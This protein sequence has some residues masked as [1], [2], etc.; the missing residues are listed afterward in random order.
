VKPPEPKPGTA[1]FRLQVQGGMAARDFDDVTDTEADAI[2]AEVLGCAKGPVPHKLGYVLKAV[3]D[4]KD[5]YARWLSG[6]PR[7]VRSPELQ[8]RPWCGKCREA[9]RGTYD[10]LDRFVRC[11]DCYGYAPRFQEA[12]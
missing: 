7:R 4:E 11:P 5:P 6:R 8:P 9:D 2:A 12:V 1:E 10:E 3:R